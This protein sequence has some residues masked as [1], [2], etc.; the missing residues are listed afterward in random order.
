MGRSFAYLGIPPLHVF[1]GEVALAAFLVLGPP[2]IHGRWPWV[3]FRHPS[4]RGFRKAFLILLLF[5]TLQVVHGVLSGYPLL[6]AMRDLAF[7]YYP[8]YFFLG[9]W[10]GL[11]DPEY[12]SKTLRLAAWVNGIYG[13]LFIV[14][15][16]QLPWHFPGV[17]EEIQ[18]VL[19]FGQSSFSGA[20][21][22]AL[23]SFERDLRRVWVPLLL[24]ALVLLGMLIRAEWFAFALGLLVWAWAT[25]NLKRV[26]VA[27]VVVMAIFCLMYLTNFTYEAPQTR[28]GTISARDIIGRVIAPIDRDAATEYTSDVQQFA[29]NALWRTLFWAQIWSSVHENI[30]RSIFG[31][32]YGFPLNDLLPDLVD[33]GTRSPHN[34]FFLILG[35]T[36]WAGVLVFGFFQM[37]LAK[38]LHGA[39][40]MSEQPFGIVFW[41]AMLAFS[42]FTPFF[43]TPFGAIPFF[44]LTGC[45]CAPLFCT[46]K[47]T[48]SEKRSAT[49]ASSRFPAP[50]PEINALPSPLCLEAGK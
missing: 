36:G 24:N 26:A 10:T 32:G 49:T 20:I 43:E 1:M 15:L 38:L 22:L 41:A 47:A 42:V 28:G 44:L 8:L 46:V 30:T 14:V 27:G 7:N 33:P 40:K 4:L 18:P 5:G 25:K 39:Y 16:S 3:A 9:L 13:I 35:Y 6:K 2:S 29:G 45:A 11:R 23:L 31:Y 50:P 48:A 12:L 19:L 34:V 37:K 17:G 21:L